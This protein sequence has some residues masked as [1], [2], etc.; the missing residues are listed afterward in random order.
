[1][2]SIG[3]KG[4]GGIRSFDGDWQK[5]YSSLKEGNKVFDAD[6]RS[7]VQCSKS[8]GYIGI[9]FDV[10]GDEQ[11]DVQLSPATMRKFIPANGVKGTM[12]TTDDN[13]GK[14]VY[15]FKVDAPYIPNNVSAELRFDI[16]KSGEK[17]EERELTVKIGEEQ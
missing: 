15:F 8:D 11:L 5:L 6:K 17:A 12:I 13:E 14:K 3:S 9:E 16:L 2:E 10:G 4:A 1:M 7:N